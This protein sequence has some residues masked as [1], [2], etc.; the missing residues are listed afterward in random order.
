V[1]KY[2]IDSVYYYNHGVE[3]DFYIPKANLAVQVSYALRDAET[4]E[5]ETR[6]LVKMREHLDC[7]KQVIV[8]YED[9]NTLTVDGTTIT[10]IPAWKFILQ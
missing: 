10:I 6:A 1:N 8:T 5:R 3:V 2:G 4:T 7:D 9:E